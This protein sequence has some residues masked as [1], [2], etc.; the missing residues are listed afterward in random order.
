MKPGVSEE[1]IKATL[2]VRG[3]DGL[4]YDDLQ[5]AFSKL[6]RVKEIRM[7]LDRFTGGFKNFAF[8]EFESEQEADLVVKNSGKEQVR[9][10]GRPISVVKSRER[11]V[12][13]SGN[14]EKKETEV[15]VQKEVECCEKGRELVNEVFLSNLNGKTGKSDE[16]SELWVDRLKQSI[17]I[18]FKCQKWFDTVELGKIHEICHS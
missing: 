15:K 18:C 14:A 13:E 10:A 17:A 3:I 12:V 2:M 4:E 6:G 1:N 8:V 11:K 16:I 5:Q 9:V 7:I